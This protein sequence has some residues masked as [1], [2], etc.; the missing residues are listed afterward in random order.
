[1]QRRAAS[2][3]SI[4]QIDS[5]SYSKDRGAIYLDMMI[6]HSTLQSLGRISI[7]SAPLEVYIESYKSGKPIRKVLRERTLHFQTI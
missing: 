6:T 4:S 2:M 1:M 5:V 7:S 3:I